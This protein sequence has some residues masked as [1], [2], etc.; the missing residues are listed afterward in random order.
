[1]S[2]LLGTEAST[3]SDLNL[4]LQIIVLI[5][6]LVGVKFGK[7]KTPSSFEKHGRI[8]TIAV[9]LNA[10]G[11][12]SVMGPSFVNYFSTPIQKL[13]II[14]IL[15]TSLHALFGSIAEILGIAFVFNKKPKNIRLSMRLTMLFWV[16]AALLG[17]ALYLQIAGII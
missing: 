11:F 14:G 16:I 4:L 13:S 10:I 15:S 2:G 9:V 12:V 5:I 6:L 17:I 7:E 1:M 8:M 3:A